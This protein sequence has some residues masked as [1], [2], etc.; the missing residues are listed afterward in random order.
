MN[1]EKKET[2][3]CGS[4]ILLSLFCEIAKILGRQ[5][6][7]NFRGKS[8]S[9]QLF[10]PHPYHYQPKQDKRP[11]IVNI[12]QLSPN[13]KY[14]KCFIH[15]PSPSKPYRYPLFD[16]LEILYF[17]R[18]ATLFRPAC[19]HPVAVLHYRFDRVCYNVALV[20]KLSLILECI[21]HA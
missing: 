20:N 3:K 17:N 10:A 18:A 14:Q 21:I 9:L 12:S 7:I 16:R 1:R 19:D 15:L 13:D 6:L 2:F 8:V 11:V 4:Q 5:F